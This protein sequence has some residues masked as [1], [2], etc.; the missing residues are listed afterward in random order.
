V[1]WI[2]LIVTKYFADRRLWQSRFLQDVVPA[3]SRFTFH[4]CNY[5]TFIA[6]H[7]CC[8]RTT[9]IH[10]CRKGYTSRLTNTLL[11]SSKQRLQE[12]EHNTIAHI[13]VQ[14]FQ[15]N[16]FWHRGKKHVSISVVCLFH[17]KSITSNPLYTLVLSRKAT[18]LRSVLLLLIVTCMQESVH[19]ST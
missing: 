3:S 8:R 10:K 6:W 9:C 18:L 1:A 16:Y 4:I 5:S 2:Q 15:F 13:P 17:D 7:V 11:L 14:Q 12:V 19:S